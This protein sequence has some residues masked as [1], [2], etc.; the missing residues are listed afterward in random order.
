MF[1]KYFIRV[2]IFIFSVVYGTYSVVR[3]LKFE[4]YIFDLG[5]YD[6]LIWLISRG[7]PLFSSVIEAHPWVDHFSPSLFLL[8]PLYW[9]WDS[10]LVLL[11][12]QAVFISLGAYP[13]YLL[14]L[15]KTKSIVFS[16]LLAVCYL[17]FYGLQNAVAY[18]F[19]AVTLGPTLMAFIFWF[20]E[21]KRYK[22]F[23]I[24][25]VVFTGLQENFFI[26]ASALGLFF[27][28]KYRDYKR[29]I[30]IMVGG[31]LF[32]ILLIFYLIPGFFG[33]SYYYL[34]HFPQLD[35]GLMIKM[36]Y[37]PFSKVD[38]MVFSLLSFGFLPLISPAFLVLLGEEFLGRFLGTT[39]P[40]W[41]IL[42]FHYN[43]I[44]AP[45][46]AFAAVTTIQK[47]LYKRIYIAIILITVG[48]VISL[49]RV[50]PDIY[51]MFNKG[52]Y[53]TGHTGNAKVVIKYLPETGSVA[54]SNNLGAQI[55]HREGLI[56]LTNCIDNKS[57]WGP[58]GKR[59][60]K[61]TPDYILA[62]ID[63]VG[64]NNYY[65]DYDRDSIVKYLDSV[66]ASGDYSLVKNA[67]YVFLLKRN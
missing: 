37:T 65:P 18:D 26:L 22:W 21:E 44:L 17:L 35:P 54:A 48:T 12:F 15:K 41:W 38:V 55:A 53:D 14:S 58:D 49:I 52:F 30:P 23:W 5:Y 7:R 61:V 8:V 16:S 6:Q 13:I 45:I 19:H 64:F 43:A 63:P 28:V 10:P 27:I 42:G 47:Y 9:I 2:L 60:Y 62:D 34:Q 36:L 46:L 59:C 57:V 67:G 31:L 50:K 11:I 3:H 29:G 33:G 4:T 56:F 1:K 51:K 66:Q 20:Y 24:I 39:N 25:L 32:F 40:N